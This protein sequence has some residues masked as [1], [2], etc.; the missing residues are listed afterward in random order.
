MR[1]SMSKLD[2]VEVN[3]TQNYV[4]LTLRETEAEYVLLLLAQDECEK[5]RAGIEEALP[6]AQAVHGGAVGGIEIHKA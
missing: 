1:V 6:G 5:L 3:R 4:C 2:R